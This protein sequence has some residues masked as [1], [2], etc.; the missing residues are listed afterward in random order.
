MTSERQIEANWQNA[1]K[2]TEPYRPEFSAAEAQRELG[3]RRVTLDVRF[4]G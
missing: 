1:M 4:R 3:Q 2:S